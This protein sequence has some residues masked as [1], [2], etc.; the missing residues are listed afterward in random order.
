MSYTLGHN[1]FSH[2]TFDQW[3]AAIHLGLDRPSNRT[4]NPTTHRAP[5]DISTLPKEVDWVAK[6]GVTPVKD[7]GKCGSCWAFS[8][9]GALEGAYYVKYGNLVSFSEQ[10]LVDCD[11]PRHGGKD[12]GCNGGLMDNAFNFIEFNGGVCTEDDYPYVSGNTMRQGSCHQKNCK[13]LPESTPKDFA[14]VEINSEAALMSA[15]AQQPVSIAIEA[16]QRDFQ[17][18]KSGVYTAKCGANLDHGVLVVGYGVYEDGLPY[19]KVK[20][21]WS[22]TWGMEGYILLERGLTQEGGQC[23]ILDGPPSYPVL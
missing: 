14:D 4:A 17:L 12:S 11:G 2:L 13:K 18:Y 20:N 23:G 21:S 10:N 3:R 5:I 7:Q 6:G 1:Q 19:W 16:D 9:T 22:S 15:V 8:T